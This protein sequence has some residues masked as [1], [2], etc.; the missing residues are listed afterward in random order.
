MRNQIPHL[1]L[2]CLVCLVCAAGS[3]STG[4]ARAAGFSTARFAG[5]QGTPVTPN[6]TAIYFNPAS[7]AETDGFHI[8]LDGSLALRSLSYTHT[9]AATDT[10]EPKGAQ[11]ANTDQASL[12]NV[13]VAPFIGATAKLGPIAIG[14]AFYVP[15]GGVVTWNQNSAFQNNTQYP[16]IVDGAQRWNIITGTI[17]STYISLAAAYKIPR[18]GLSL[19]VSG[20]LIQ[21]KVSL[22][23]AHTA[24]RNDDITQEGRAFLDVSG[25]Q[26][27]FGAGA[28]WEALPQKLWFGASYQARPNISGG[29]KLS[30]NLNIN[31][32]GA[33]PPQSVDF[34]QDL[35]D[36]IRFGVRVA[37]IKALELRLFGDYTRWSALKSQCIVPSGGSCALNADGSPAGTAMPIQNLPRNWNDTVGVRLGASYFVNDKVEIFAGTGFDQSAVPSSTLEPGL[38]DFN[39]FAA[40]AG[41]R[42]GFLKV[43]H[44]AASYTQLIYLSRDNSGESTLATF[45]SPSNGPDA[46]GKYTQSIGVFNLNLD[47][48]FGG[49]APPPAPAPEPAAPATPPTDA[50]PPPPATPPTDVPPAAP[51]PA[52]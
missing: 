46:G 38:P 37:P 27:S 34:L 32:G 39:N 36:V 24:T 14:A 43:V 9:P 17:Q 1:G 48:A 21:S 12:F 20:N 50:P 51:A 30:G 22:L 29:M 6:A 8:F 41:L 10:P 19:G 7:L 25:W 28:L 33:L 16:G 47:F 45:K 44:L 5:E 15:F 52:P 13:G 42:V 18:I 2:G 3:L 11:G 31:L 40:A 23:T 4:A 49:S 35:P 26:G